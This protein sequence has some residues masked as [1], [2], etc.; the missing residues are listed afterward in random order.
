M[1]SSDP[2]RGDLEACSIHHGLRGDNCHLLL[3]IVEETRGSYYRRWKEKTSSLIG[4]DLASGGQAARTRCR[5]KEGENQQF[6]ES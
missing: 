4:I 2:Y 3:P 1:L 6:D 5:W